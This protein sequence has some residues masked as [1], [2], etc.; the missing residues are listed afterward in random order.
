MSIPRYDSALMFAAL[1]LLGVSLFFNLVMHF[2][3]VKYNK[4]N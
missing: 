3:I 1:L 2:F 4:Y